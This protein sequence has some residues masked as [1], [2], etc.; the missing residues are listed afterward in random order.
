MDNKDSFTYKTYLKNK[1]IFRFIYLFLIATI[2]GL[3]LL[4]FILTP[5]L[6]NAGIYGFIFILV[7]YFI[8]GKIWTYW[9]KQ[10]KEDNK[11][12][13]YSWGK[14]AGAELSTLQDL[15]R[16]GSDYK[17]I[18]DFPTG[19]GNTDFIVVCQKGIFTIEVKATKGVISYN[20]GIY[21]NG[22]VS[23]FVNIKQAQAE[24]LGLK[25][26]L[27]NKFNK[28]YDVQGILEFRNAQIDKY[29]IHGKIEHIWIGGRSFY[30]YVFKKS[31]VNLSKEEVDSIYSYLI[32]LKN[33]KDKSEIS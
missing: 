24:A 6:T 16:L 20:N 1:K 4:F 11:K 12:N 27:R 8:A 10:N 18:P 25:D 33:E 13:Y 17:I 3:A 5:T 14:G 15:E 30:N 32:E 2:A 19:T 22:K 21:V 31:D 23:E 7:I 28:D 9:F 26:L 29:S